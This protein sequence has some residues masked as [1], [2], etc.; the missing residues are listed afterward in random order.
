MVAFNSRRADKLARRRLKRAEA[1]LKKGERELFYTELLKAL[2]GYLGD[3]LKMPTSELMRDNI[4]AVLSEKH[5]AEAD[6]DS[7]I[8]LIDDAEFAKYSSAGGDDMTATYRRAIDTIN[9]LEK[10]FKSL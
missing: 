1:A 6:I 5:I 4:R 9:G 7:L 10:S 2:W 3:K 8:A